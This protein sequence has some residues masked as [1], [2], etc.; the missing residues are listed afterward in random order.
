MSKISFHLF[1]LLF[2]SSRCLCSSMRSTAPR[3][4]LPVTG[5]RD[6]CW[7][8]TATALA[9]P[10]RCPRAAAALA[11]PGDDGLGRPRRSLAPAAA[12]VLAGPAV[13]AARRPRWLRWPSLPATEKRKGRTA[14]DRAARLPRPH[15]GGRAPSRRPRH[16]SRPR[17]HP[18]G[19]APSRLRPGR[20]RPR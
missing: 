19:R 16:P 4:P 13:V 17:P 5:S 9:G 1:L 3:C 14:D 7:P 11:S 6:A 15:P 18:G 12:A 20:P 2:S 8:R 10:A